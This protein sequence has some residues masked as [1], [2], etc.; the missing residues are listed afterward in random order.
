MINHYIYKVSFTD[1]I[2]VLI[3]LMSEYY[4]NISTKGNFTNTN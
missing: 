4:V 2:I 1:M 3:Y